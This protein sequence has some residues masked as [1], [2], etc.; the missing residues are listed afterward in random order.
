MG[1]PVIQGYASPFAFTNLYK[2]HFHLPTEYLPES[3]S[4]IF[5]QICS[6]LALESWI[7]H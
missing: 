1:S 6:S 5:H 2:T 3:K 7:K 4:Y